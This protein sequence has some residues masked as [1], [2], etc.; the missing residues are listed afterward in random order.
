MCDR[1]EKVLKERVNNL[2]TIQEWDL[3][4][5][6]VEG[7]SLI[8]SVGG[9]GTYLR[10]SSMIENSQQPLLGINTDPGRSL[11]ILCAKF[12]YKNRSK[13]SDINK[14]FD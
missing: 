6:D 13:E 2:S 3:R 14:I 12:L 4:H 5:E 1:F 7:K 8:V 11:G 9:D 10:T